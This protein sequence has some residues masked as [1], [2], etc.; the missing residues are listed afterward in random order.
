MLNDWAQGIQGIQ[1]MCQDVQPC[2]LPLM[3]ALEMFWNVHGVSFRHPVSQCIQSCMRQYSFMDF[4][5]CLLLAPWVASNL[6]H[7]LCS[8][9]ADRN[10]ES[11]QLQTLPGQRA[12]RAS[13]YSRGKDTFFLSQAECMASDM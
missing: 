4:G 11:T 7:V 2:V 10:S 13:A 3:C 9:N 5:V 1:N 12:N 6:C 8:L